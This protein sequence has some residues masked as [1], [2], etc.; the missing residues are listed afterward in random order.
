MGK[1]KDIDEL[2]VLIERSK[3][4]GLKVVFSNGVFDILHAGHLDY[5]EKCKQLGD[6]LVIGLNSDSSVRV[7]KGPNRPLNREEDRAA[8]L[9]GLECVDFVTLFSEE[10]PMNIIRGLKPDFLAK[11]ADYSLNEVVGKDFVESYGGEVKLIPLKEGLS[12]SLLVNKI[13]SEH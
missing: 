3:A 5:L 1:V 8:L 6:L 4:D 7:L 12:T 13:V 2:T 10:T 11:G 9:A